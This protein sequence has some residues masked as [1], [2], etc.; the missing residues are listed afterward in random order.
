M[1]RAVVRALD[2]I[3]GHNGDRATDLAWRGRL[4]VGLGLFTGLIT[5]VLVAIRMGVQGGP[6]PVSWLVLSASAALLAVPLVERNWPG[7]PA[8]ALFILTPTVTLIGM[9]V[10]EA[11][12]NSEAVLWMPMVPLAAVALVGLRGGAL[13][14]GI[15]VGGLVG[16]FGLH[17]VG[18]FPLDPMGPH[19]ALKTAAAITG[20]LFGF[21]LGLVYE[22]NRRHHLDSLRAAEAR[23]RALLDA[24]PDAVLRLDGTGRI[25]D[26]VPSHEVR[27][28]QD[29]S[30][31]V[32]RSIDDVLGSERGGPVREH[33]EQALASGRGRTLTLDFPENG[34]MAILEL[35]SIPLADG[36][37]LTIVRDMTGPATPGE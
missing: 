7:G 15:I 31:L 37:C 34:G 35:R 14:A 16:L 12:V 36:T 28:F 30:A 23:N 24:M 13:V 3:R 1:P 11:G 26:A 22:L 6:D 20:V 33:L 32:D 29:A 10:L 8:G 17:W 2:A 19:V 21:A 27:G 18:G 5:P 4:V 9:A 25:L